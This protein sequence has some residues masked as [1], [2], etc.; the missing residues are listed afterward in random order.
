[1][2]TQLRGSDLDAYSSRLREAA[3]RWWLLRRPLPPIPFEQLEPVSEPM[4]I[5]TNVHAR[6]GGIVAR[7]P[8]AMSYMAGIDGDDDR[9]PAQRHP[10]AT[11]SSLRGVPKIRL[12]GRALA[13]QLLG[14]LAQEY[15]TEAIVYGPRAREQVRVTPHPDKGVNGFH[16]IT[17]ANRH[18]AKRWLRSLAA[19]VPVAEDALLE[20]RRD[21]AIAVLLEVLHLDD[22]VEL[23]SDA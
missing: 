22:A 17:L 4:R 23:T 2:T 19:V 21:R 15:A 11:M 8:L 18:R 20:G 7:Y 10:H 6:I 1:M 9:T 12:R 3:K 13:R 5:G 14:R 16:G